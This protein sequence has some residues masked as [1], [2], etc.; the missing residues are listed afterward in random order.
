MLARRQRLCEDVRWVLQSGNVEQ[1][2]C[3]G[4][5]LIAGV[6]EMGVNMFGLI[7][8]RLVLGEC[9]E[10]LIVSE[11]RYGC[12]IVM[13]IFSESYEPYPFGRCD[14]SGDEFSFHG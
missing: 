2:D 12:K 14:R 8:V 10:R 9:Y 6:V 5:D 4:V 3:S 7:V 11:K 13:K 1:L